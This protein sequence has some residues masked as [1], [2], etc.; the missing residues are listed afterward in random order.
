M[1]TFICTASGPL[2]PSQQGSLEER[3]TWRNVVTYK[4]GFGRMY[5]VVSN[6]PGAWDMA[7]RA[8]SERFADA[9]RWGPG[10]RPSLRTVQVTP[11]IREYKE[12]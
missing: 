2:A 6:V 8:L 4:D 11:M 3:A 9:D 12:V 1:S 10:Y 5:A 7:Q